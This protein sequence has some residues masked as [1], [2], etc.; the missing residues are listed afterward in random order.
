VYSVYSVVPNPSEQETSFP[1]S[2]AADTK[3]PVGPITDIHCH[4]NWLDMDIHA[5]A[6]HF[7]S[8]GVDRVWVL[9]WV[10]WDRRLHGEYELPT[11]DCLEAAYRYPDLFVP[12]CSIDPREPHLP[13]KIKHYVELGCRGFGEFKVRLCIDN[14]DS[15]VVYRTCSELGLP[16]LFHM[17]IWIDGVSY[18]YNADCTR[19]PAVLEEFPDTTFIGHGPGFWREISGDADEN[20]DVYPEGP[21]TPGGRLPEMLSKYDNLYADMSAGS[22]RKALSRDPEFCRQFI[23]DFSHKLM[24]GTDYHDRALLDLLESY[25][26]PED[27]FAAIAEGNARKLVP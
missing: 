3:T 22:G 27:V 13:D 12:F 10:E 7:R 11:I 9:G 19:L 25:E 16:L 8:L 26:L 23:L 14:P 15:K 4:V 2:D 20:R 1:M 24:Y 17:D 18:W 6:E 5:W 21:V